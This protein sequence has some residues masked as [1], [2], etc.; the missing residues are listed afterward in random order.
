MQSVLLREFQWLRIF[1][2][3]F[4]RKPGCYDHAACG[5]LA[6]TVHPSSPNAP[7]AVS[8][9]V[10][11]LECKLMSWT[12]CEN[13]WVEVGHRLCCEA[14][15][16]PRNRLQPEPSSSQ[17]LTATSGEGRE[18]TSNTQTLRK[19][20]R[21]IRWQKIQKRAA[22]SGKASLGSAAYERI[23][24]HVDCSHMMKL[25]KNKSVLVWF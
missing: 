15:G 18:N 10:E 14:P 19:R 1:L 5:C 3:D 17:R 8:R 21:P 13:S 23:L 20:L 22:E 24:F 25:C 12:F 2:T 11:N 4:L 9:G 16:Q 6:S 7:H